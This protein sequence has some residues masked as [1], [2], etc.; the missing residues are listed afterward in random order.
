MLLNEEPSEISFK[1]THH[2]TELPHQLK[3]KE[4][5]ELKDIDE[6][7]RLETQLL[8][9]NSEVKKLMTRFD[10]HQNKQ[11][12]NDDQH[13]KDF[14]KQVQDLHEKVLTEQKKRQ[15]DQ[16]TLTIRV[17]KIQDNIQDIV[18]KS[19]ETVHQTV[20]KVQETVQQKVSKSDVRDILKAEV[21]E[22]RKN[23]TAATQEMLENSE[24]KLREELSRQHDQREKVGNIYMYASLVSM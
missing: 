8:E 23:M 10:Q 12:E 3:Q 15:E 13:K 9:L 19:Q 5:A 18:S 17:S 20:S 1:D 21:S 14:S 6:L 16:K 4:E 11:K 24:R 7:K 22:F 2:K